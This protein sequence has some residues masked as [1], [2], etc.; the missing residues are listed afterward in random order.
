MSNTSCRSSILLVPVA[1]LVVSLSGCSRTIEMDTLKK[2]ITDGVAA[3][4]GLQPDTVTCPTEPRE[5][6]IN[7]EFECTVIPKEGGRLTIKVTQKDDQGNVNWVVAKTEGLLN[8]A[9][10]ET[11]VQKGLKEQAEVDATVS[12]GGRWKGAKKGDTFDC[13]AKTAAGE[14]VTVMVSVTDDEGNVEWG[15]R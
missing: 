6:K 11:S 3:Q 5:V 12:C 15:T 1:L 4:V 14:T 9:K 7:D 2:S 10:V 13:E 8:L